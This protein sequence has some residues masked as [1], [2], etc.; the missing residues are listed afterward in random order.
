MIGKTDRSISWADAALNEATTM[1]KASAAETS[2]R[3][4]ESVRPSVYL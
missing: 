3:K 1:L 2:A 4:Y